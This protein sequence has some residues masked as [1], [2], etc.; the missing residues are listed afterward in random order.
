MKDNGGV[1]SNGSK[2]TQIFGACIGV[3]LIVLEMIICAQ[4]I[5]LD[6]RP[7]SWRIGL[8][9]GSSV[10][11]TVLYF[12][13]FYAIKTLK[14]RI[15]VYCIDFAFLLTICA[16]TGSAYIAGLYGV[17]LSQ[18]YINVVEMKTKVIVL[19]FTCVAFTVMC[20]VGLYIS[21]MRA[22][23]YSE[24]IDLASACLVGLIILA[25]HFAVVNFL[26]A[27]YRNNLKLTKA[28]KEADENK[29]Q[30]EQAYEQLEETA[31]FQERN[32]IARDIHDNAGHSMTSVIMQTEAAKLLIDTNPEEAKSKIISANIQAK[33]A[34]EQMRESVHLLAGRNASRSLKEEIEEILAQTMDSTDIIIRYDIA[35]I[36]LSGD[37]RRFIANS[38]KE[39]LS[40]G[41]RHGGAGAFYVELGSTENVVCL[42]VSD[43]GSGLPE[44]FKEGFGLKGIREKAAQFGGGIVYESESGDGCEIKITIKGE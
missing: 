19:V 33:N 14:A 32:R 20:V 36:Q 8:L 25:L 34:L 44:D 11:I 40:N 1:L 27:F 24:I 30:L 6:P 39:C 4:Y 17:I 42:I 28:L 16:L 18:L 41:M 38:L 9:I 13:E 35:D 7:D 23:T 37:K 43:N 26:L 2:F 10:A 15:A 12:V 22:I 29:K 31:V 3:I 21:L 5:S